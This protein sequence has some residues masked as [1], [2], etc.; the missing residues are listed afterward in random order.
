[1]Q[2]VQNAM[3]H[4]NVIHLLDDKHYVLKGETFRFAES[5]CVKIEHNTFKAHRI[6]FN[7]L[8]VAN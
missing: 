3:R 2:C 7:I 4:S 8:S 6:N 1:M 5:I